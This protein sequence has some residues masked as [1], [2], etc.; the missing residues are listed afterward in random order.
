MPTNGASTRRV[1]SR[2]LASTTAPH[3]TNEDGV[4][5]SPWVSFV[6]IEI[7]GLDELREALHAAGMAEIGLLVQAYRVVK[8]EFPVAGPRPAAHTGILA[9]CEAARP[10]HCYVVYDL[11]WALTHQTSLA[12]DYLERW[13][14]A[15]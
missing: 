6:P 11:T 3:Y 10:A 2:V 9:V 14:K 5:L 7:H 12:L 1:M 4:V 8:L 13:K 15:S